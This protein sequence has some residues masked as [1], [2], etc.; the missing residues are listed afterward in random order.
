MQVLQSPIVSLLIRIIFKKK[1][2]YL[3][4]LIFLLCKLFFG[5]RGIYDYSR[6]ETFLAKKES[7]LIR[8]EKSNQALLEDI[9]KL[10]VDEKFQK[11]LARDELGV[12]SEDEFIVIFGR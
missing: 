11:K 3:A 4:L 8:L 6:N 7:A 9:T 5:H 1:S 12:L 2:F 10:R